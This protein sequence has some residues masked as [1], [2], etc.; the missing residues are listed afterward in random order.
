MVVYYAHHGKLSNLLNISKSN[1][2]KLSVSFHVSWH[3]PS[4]RE[5]KG[6]DHYKAPTES[7]LQSFSQESGRGPSSN[8]IQV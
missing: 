4:E 8:H 2:T 6:L 7:F 1:E 5:R 3:F